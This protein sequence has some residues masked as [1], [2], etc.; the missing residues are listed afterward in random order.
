MSLDMGMKICN[1]DRVP[2]KNRFLSGV[3]GHSEPEIPATNPTGLD[4]SQQLKLST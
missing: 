2:R 3:S 4:K 1:H